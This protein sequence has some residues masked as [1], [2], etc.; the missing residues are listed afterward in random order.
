MG[1]VG[2]EWT[3][4]RRTLGDSP[5]GLR[6]ALCWLP[7]DLPP[8][9]GPPLGSVKDSLSRE[10]LPPG[11]T[12]SCGRRGSCGGLPVPTHPKEPT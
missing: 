6:C 10:P 12:A 5:P 2:W 1:T 4:V 7:S 3:R 11:E 9:V 8:S